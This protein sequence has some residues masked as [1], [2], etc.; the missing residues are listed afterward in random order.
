MIG[1]I[2]QAIGAA[3]WRT[4]LCQIVPIAALPLVEPWGATSTRVLNEIAT[5]SGDYAGF[6]A[7]RDAAL[8]QYAQDLGV[9]SIV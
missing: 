4:L 9:P 6:S 5:R 7:T 3:D 1:A 8:R 2:H